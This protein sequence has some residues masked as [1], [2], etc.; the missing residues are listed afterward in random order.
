M[1]ENSDG[2]TFPDG[3]GVEVDVVD[4]TPE[5]DRGRVPLG[6]TADEVLP[7]DEAEEYS[8]KVRT[9]LKELKR[10]SHDERRVAEQAGRERDEALK[11]SR[12]IMDENNRLKGYINNGEQVFGATIKDAAQTKI[13]AARRLVKE[14]YESGDAE[15]VA[16]ASMRLNSAQMELNNAHSFRPTPLQQVDPDVYI[17]Q[18]TQAAPRPSQRAVEWQSRNQWF[19]TDDEMSSFAFGV[20]KKLIQSGVDPESDDYY[21]RLDARLRQVFPEQLGG[22]RQQNSPPATVVA[23]ATRGTAPVRVTLSASQ[24]SVAKRMGLT[25]QQYAAQV[26]LLEQKNG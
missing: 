24:V 18:P 1:A 15:K 13:E 14:A 8:A 2:Y 25:P 3:E 16:D 26:K 19:G 4:D 10:V 11:L 6:K 23:G 21:N 7:D 12:A 17:P 5:R 22:T 9:K 20:H